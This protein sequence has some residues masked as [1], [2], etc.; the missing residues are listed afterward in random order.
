MLSKPF[1]LLTMC[2]TVQSADIRLLYVSSPLG[3]VTHSCRDC[4]RFIGLRNTLDALS[5]L[6]GRAVCDG[7][8]RASTSDTRSGTLGL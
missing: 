6:A 1:F 2:K 5:L 8:G 3:F 4:R 7:N